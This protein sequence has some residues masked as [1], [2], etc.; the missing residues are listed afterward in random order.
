[1]K[2]SQ[3][4]IHHFR[5]FSTIIFF[6]KISFIKRKKFVASK[7][8]NDLIFDEIE[9]IKFAKFLY[10]KVEFLYEK[11]EISKS[12]FEKS[13]FLTKSIVELFNA[14]KHSMTKSTNENENFNV[15]S[16]NRNENSK[17]E[18]IIFIEMKI[19][20]VDFF[21]N[22]QFVDNEKKNDDF[23]HENDIKKRLIK[24]FFKMFFLLIRCLIFEIQ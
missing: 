5:H 9:I 13:N 8:S 20:N 23:D 10:E 12:T 6:V 19:T 16:T 22:I 15:E 24:F 21:K 1:M 18:L 3:N 14:K 11:I 7:H 17:I 4:V 2:Q